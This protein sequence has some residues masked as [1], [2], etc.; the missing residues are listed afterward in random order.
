MSESGRP[1]KRHIGDQ[2]KAR[3][4][5]L[6]GGWSV[7]VSRDKPRDQPDADLAGARA[8]S[9]S[10]FD[11][12]IVSSAPRNPGLGAD[13]TELM[14]SGPP[15][16]Q[17]IDIG[18][19]D[20][21]GA[22][23]D[24]L[25]QPGP[26]YPRG[27][28]SLHGHGHGHGHGQDQG[29]RW[30]GKSPHL[31][32]LSGEL[33][34]DSQAL[35]E[36]IAEVRGAPAELMLSDDNLALDE[37]IA[38]VRGEPAGP[39]PAG[40]PASLPG[41]KPPDSVESSLGMFPEDAAVSDPSLNIVGGQSVSDG[42]LRTLSNVG[43]GAPKPAGPKAADSGDPGERKPAR[44]KDIQRWP[45]RPA[46]PRQSGL[47]DDVRYVF[48]VVTGV[49]RV[50]RELRR[51][52]ER[53]GEES[54]ARLAKIMMLAREIVGDS[55]LVLPAL[56]AS[57]EALVDIEERRSQL[58]GVVAAADADIEVINRTRA[59]ES[60]ANAAAL[61]RLDRTV[62]D[63]DQALEP[64][65]RKAAQ[66]RKRCS[67]LRD[68][69]DT[70]GDRIR[71]LEANLGRIGD[72]AGRAGVEAEL[73]SVRAEREAVAMD[74]PAIIAKLGELEPE[75]ATLTGE[76]SERR[77][78]IDAMRQ[79]ERESKASAEDKRSTAETGKQ[80]I[81][82]DIARADSERDQALR[83]LGEALCRERPRRL[84]LRL[85][86]IDLHDD[87]I[88]TLERHIYELEELVR[89]INRG[90]LARGLL[91]IIAA[92]AAPAAIIWMLA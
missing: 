68:T 20:L 49:A 24:D 22:T 39:A 40:K 64:L 50:R 91:I 86:P 79:R 47:L 65:E 77:A 33:T 60:E 3:I 46:L 29:G 81:Q 42:S 52:R 25:V 23:D 43:V 76:R 16:N 69:L 53:L 34:D 14:D 21:P 72:G 80:A 67:A 85:R 63:L 62:A 75:I 88:T 19:D 18:D 74:E 36:V 71:R 58:A 66:V 9:D 57:R 48:T 61:A 30:R 11:I 17:E 83:E 41:S 15:M 54:D 89:G 92:V 10:S 31:L 37:I 5:D 35:D 82:A 26:G 44:P 78:E 51:L 56:D 87:A 12:E 1:P 84:A 13:A 38:E 6:A 73:A 27:R 4:D 2:T 90:A 70:L 45:T 59:T 7:S 55:S 28:Q 8:A 32:P